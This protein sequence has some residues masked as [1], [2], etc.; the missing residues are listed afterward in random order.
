MC[1]SH[2]PLKS[3][4]TVISKNNNN[5]HNRLM[6]FGSKMTHN[7]NNATKYLKSCLCRVMLPKMTSLLDTV[8]N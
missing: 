8:D 5:T 6:A 1:L 4:Q 3:Q 7:N 2:K